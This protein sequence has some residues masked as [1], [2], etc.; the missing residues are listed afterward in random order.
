MKTTI[1]IKAP[2]INP[3]CGVAVAALARNSAGRMKHRGDRRA[4]DARRTREQTG[5]WV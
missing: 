5:G 1:R 3:R 2:V 4:K